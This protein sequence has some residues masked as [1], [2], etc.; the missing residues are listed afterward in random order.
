M[1]CVRYK[2]RIMVEI[3]FNICNDCCNAVDFCN[4]AVIPCTV[5]SINM[6]QYYRSICNIAIFLQYYITAS[7]CAVWKRNRR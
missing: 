4:L 5:I 1:A 3:F 2:M 7:F 6:L